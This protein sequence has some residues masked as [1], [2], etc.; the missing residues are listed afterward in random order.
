MGKKGFTIIEAIMTLFIL[1]LITTIFLP[2]AISGYTN[3]KKAEEI[4]NAN[5]NAQ[6]EID[7]SIKNAKD[8]IYD[9]YSG[10]L[11]DSPMNS[12]IEVFGKTING[13]RTTNKGFT[14]FIGEEPQRFDEREKMPFV[15]DIEIRDGNG[16]TLKGGDTAIYWNNDIITGYNRIEENDN[17]SMNLYQWYASK[18]GFLGYV[19]NISEEDLNYKIKFPKWPDD[20][21]QIKQE[22]DFDYEK[23]RLDDLGAYINKHIVY[24]VIP[25]ALSGKYGIEVESKEIYIMGPPVLSTNLTF[26]MDPYTLRNSSNAFYEDKAEIGNWKD[27]SKTFSQTYAGNKMYIDYI[28][29]G[30]AIMLEN[31]QATIKNGSNNYDPISSAENF[32]IF[33]VYKNNDTILNKQNL[34]KRISSA[35]R[36]F[37]LIFNNGNELEFK[38]SNSN[39][40]SK[41]IYRDLDTNEKCIITGRLQKISTK[42]KIKLMLDVPQKT[43]T[44][45]EQELTFNLTKETNGVLYLGDSA[46][47]QSIYELIIYNTALSDNDIKDVKEYLAKKHKINVNL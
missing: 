27:Y 38:V 28:N 23:Q 21:E 13:I 20:Y 11:T 29:D 15:K 46:S 32:T 45:V 41:S 22:S 9:Y 14:V 25:V 7:I 34:V 33:I 17:H 31:S 39:T 1:G 43:L 18:D 47:K 44:P 10:R 6:K 42:S 4:N 35:G 3:I 30:R 2:S 24:S 37:E 36:G 16:N 19:P 40:I 8:S 26:H 12:E 5:L